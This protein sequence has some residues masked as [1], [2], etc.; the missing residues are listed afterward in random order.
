LVIRTDPGIGSPE[1]YIR[2]SGFAEFRS[3]NNVI[4]KLHGQIDKAR[5]IR[6]YPDQQV[7]VISWMLLH[8]PLFRQQ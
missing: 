7:P 5:A 4:L 6:G 2:G 8:C 1:T 3:G